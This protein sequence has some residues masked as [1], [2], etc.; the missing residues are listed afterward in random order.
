MNEKQNR[1]CSCDAPLLEADRIELISL[2]DNSVDFLSE[3][4]KEA[5]TV[6]KWLKKSK[7]EKWV[8]EH[9]RS[10]MAEHGFSMLV[11]IFWNGNFNSIL[12]DAG[13]TPEGVVT[14][15]TRMGLD[16]REVESIVLSHGH[17]DHFGGLKSVLKVIAKADLPILVHEDMF[18]QRGV[19]K[20]DG[21]IRKRPRLP[22][23]EQVRPAKYIRTKKP[24]LLADKRALV[25]GEIPR[26]M[27]F[28]KGYVQNRVFV[29]G[30]WQPDPWIWDDRALVVNVKQ[31]GLVVISGCA[32]SGIINTLIHAQKITRTE[33]IY[34]VFGG[35]HLSGKEYEQRID[36]TVEK[37]TQINPALVVPSHCTGWKGAFAIARAM[38]EAFAWNSVGNIYRL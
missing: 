8:D 28:E 37:L 14:N 29:D 3:T 24:Y 17:I 36:Q 33:R 32:H 23:D 22:D 6:R 20:P 2:I 26:V 12:F 35:F 7:G 27:E 1:T 4:V 16:L 18:K 11:R 25:T 38:P 13:T 9:F 31:K 15:A 19:Q 30:K 10:P 21:G 5:Q 34:A